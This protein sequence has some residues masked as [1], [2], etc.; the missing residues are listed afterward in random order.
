SGGAKLFENSRV[1]RIQRM[2][3]HVRLRCANGAGIT[4]GTLLLCGNGLMQGLDAG[5]DAHILPLHNFMVVTEPLD[6]PSILPTRCAVSDS[7]FIVNYFRKTP[8]NRLLFGGGEGYG[9]GFPADIAGRVRRNLVKLYP[10]LA[11]VEITHAW[12][13]TIAITRNRA[14]FVRRLS[15]DLLVSA[16]YSGQGV[17]LAPYFGKLMARAVMGDSE[18][19]DLLARLPVPAFPGGQWLRRPLQTAGLG[20]YGLRD[21]L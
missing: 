16:G 11:N 8:D 1:V 12:G 2:Q 13:G 20:Y 15:P 7:R 21:R 3:D 17:V 18:G 4:C 10:R 19:L 14:P 5:V 9:A 6:D